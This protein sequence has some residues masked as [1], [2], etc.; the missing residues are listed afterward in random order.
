MRNVT[1]YRFFG[2]EEKQHYK[3]ELNIKEMKKT[4]MQN[5]YNKWCEIVQNK[6]DAVLAN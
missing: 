2:K 4:P 3:N 6:V 5:A 1:G